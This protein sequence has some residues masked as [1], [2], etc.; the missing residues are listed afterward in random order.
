MSSKRK[1]SAVKG[2]I[3]LRTPALDPQLEVKSVSLSHPRPTSA[4]DGPL[5]STVTHR[6]TSVHM[7]MSGNHLE[8]IQF[9]ILKSPKLLLILGYPWGGAKTT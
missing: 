7:L 2:G 3:L 5:V 1:G 9:H 8:T 6:T 4:L